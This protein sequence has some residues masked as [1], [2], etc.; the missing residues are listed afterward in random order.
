MVMAD[1]QSVPVKTYL[2]TDTD[3]LIVTCSMVVI[4]LEVAIV[5]H[6][7]MFHLKWLK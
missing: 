6:L 1:R 2:Y 7:V 5:I 4:T 3:F